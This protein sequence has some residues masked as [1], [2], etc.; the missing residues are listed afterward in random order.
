MSS[1]PFPPVNLTGALARCKSDQDA[2][3]DIFKRDVKLLERRATQDSGTGGPRLL[4][5]LAN[6]RRM[7]LEPKL[8]TDKV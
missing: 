4:T 3:K 5:N 1:I 7:S 8:H 2:A 6:G